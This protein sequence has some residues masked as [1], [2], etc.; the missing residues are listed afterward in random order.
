M[1]NKTVGPM[2]LH[3]FPTKPPHLAQRDELYGDDI[4]LKNIKPKKP[5]QLELPFEEFKN[6]K[7]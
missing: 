5:V 6:E 4:P 1:T 2:L 7:N 3:L